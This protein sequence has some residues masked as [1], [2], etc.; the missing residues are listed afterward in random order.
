MIA[1]IEGGVGAVIETGETGTET[2]TE[3]E[4][5]IGDGE[6]GART[7]NEGGYRY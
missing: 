5:G 6:A 4:T 1:E 7:K 3:I 2:G